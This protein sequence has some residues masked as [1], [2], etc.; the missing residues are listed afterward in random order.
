MAAW[1]GV[2]IVIILGL[3]FWA[4][5]PSLGLVSDSN[6]KD[7]TYDEMVQFITE[8]STNYNAYI[9]GSY[10]C[11]DFSQDVVANAKEQ[12]IRAAVVH[13]DE[14]Y[15]YG[16]AIV[17]FETTDK[18]LYFLEPQLDVI[19]NEAE[20]DS[21]VSRGRYDIQTY[22]GG[23]YVTGEYFDMQ[24]DGYSTQTYN[25]VPGFEIL[26]FIIGITTLIILKRRKTCL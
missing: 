5:G 6:I 1:E 3:G 20:M 9:P 10:V 4:M 25:N 2:V 21:M 11:E 16:H 12:N 22:Y 18:G 13:L 23:P 24:L 17:C 15:G 8:D 7:P 19:F 14:P 26:L